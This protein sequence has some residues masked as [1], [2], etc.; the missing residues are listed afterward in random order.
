MKQLIIDAVHPQETRVAII[1]NGKLNHLDIETH[2]RKLIKS[3][4]YLAKIVR[5]E[6]SLQAAFV[7]YGE[8]RHGFLPFTEIHPD[9]YRIP[10]ADRQELEAELAS[11]DIEDID[12]EEE[13]DLDEEQNKAKTSN[14]TKKRYRYKIQEVV[15]NRQILLVQVVK[16]QRGS[17]GAALTTFLSLPGRY[18]VLMPNA[19]RSGGGISRKVQNE[20]DRKRLK[21]ILSELNIPN[22]MAVIV[23]TAGQERNK[24]EIKRDY[25]YLIN[26]WEDL[27]KKT[28]D[29][30]AP[31]MIYEEGDIIK[32]TLRDTYRSDI[33]EVLVEG[34]EAY[35][36]AKDF[37]KKLVP[38][39]AKRIKQYKESQPILIA[40]KVEDQISEMMQPVVSLPSGGSLVI[41]HTEALV[42]IDVNSGKA[43]RERHINDTALKTN[44]E[45]AVEVAKQMRLRDLSGLLVIDFIDMDDGRHVQKVE[46]KFRE[47]IKDDRARVQMNHIS[48]FGLLEVSRQRLRPSF[49]DSHSKPCEHCHGT[50]NQRSDDSIARQLL[51]ELEIVLKDLKKENLTI[52]LN[53]S[54]RDVL[55]NTYRRDIVKLED[56]YTIRL[57]FATEIITQHPFFTIHGLEKK[58]EKVEEKTKALNNRKNRRK[59][60]SNK[61]PADQD[62]APNNAPVIEKT[63]ELKPTNQGNITVTAATEIKDQPQKKSRNRRRNNFKKMQEKQA[64]TSIDTNNTQQEKPAKEQEN[65]QPNQAAKIPQKNHTGEK[66]ITPHRVNTKPDKVEKPANT[67]EPEKKKPQQKKGWLR[68]LLD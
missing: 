43:T 45:A 51:R 54:T 68:R 10:I 15:Q 19:G 20:K 42:A 23:R 1:E 55:L 65:K 2:D 49:F 60:K 28:L 48:Q 11:E 63:P 36:K 5:I 27:R 66:K 61:A 40:H 47:S 7:E 53:P 31:C 3:N 8:D 22:N 41:N 14:T 4:I 32:R 13:K 46:Q 59:V 50:G 26:L 37:I 44:L 18:C 67:V 64:V 56:K 29:S 62:T 17:K 30:V 34:E 35:K 16:E 52:G 6:P 39:H 38:S 57:N 25:D 12:P 21:N 9:Y 58:L 24:T 33:D